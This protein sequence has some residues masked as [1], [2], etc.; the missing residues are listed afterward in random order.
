MASDL[1]SP[2]TMAYLPRYEIIYDGA[3]FHVTWQCHNRDWLLQWEWAKRAY[4][5]LLLKYKNRYGVEIYSYNFMDN[6]P[7]LAGKLDSKEQFS[8][9]FRL[10]NSRFARIV[11]KQLKRRG[12]VVM[13]RFKSPIIESDHQMLTVM[14]YIDLN[15]HRAKKVRHPRDNDWSSYG[16]Y[17]YGREDPL[18]TPSPS[19]LALSEDP[20]ERRREYRAIVESIIEHRKELNISHTYFIGNPDWV[21]GKYRELCTRLGR[22]INEAIF[23]RL[24]SPPGPEAEE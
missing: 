1:L 19:Y 3:F 12:Q 10:V 23:L 17:A 13:D 9:F 24:T 6:H 14:A 11:N 15:Q 7:H 21:L 8:A 22:K 16:Y 18:I 5:D 4:Y 20:I 2:F